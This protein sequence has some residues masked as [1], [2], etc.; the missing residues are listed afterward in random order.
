[1]YWIYDIPNWLLGLMTIAAF[2]AI[3][4]GG[5]MACRPMMGRFLGASGQYND[6]VSYLFA[7]VGVLYGLALGL[8]AVA[9]WA[10]FTDVDGK[11]SKEAA[12]LAALYRDLD[13]YPAPLR[14]SLEKRLRDYTNFVIQKD[15]PAHRQGLILD[16]G[17][18]I[19]EDIENELIGFEPV[20]EREKIAHAEVLDSLDAALESR[21]FRIQSVNSGLPP[22]L[23]AVVLFGA[24]L[25]IAMT[26]LF[27]VENF[28]LH[29]LLVAAFSASIGLLVFLTAAMDNPFRGEFS[30]SSDAYASVLE[31]A[32][33]PSPGR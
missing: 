22:V 11:A 30:V 31:K 29:A 7:A 15:W 26:Y 8:I 3:S 32:M 9:T 27:W 25:N 2:V 20:K 6:V 21:D 1:M 23:W 4:V 33:K 19:L 10:N 12:S 28:R 13:G 14:E 17:A 24:A 5:L 18:Q 16:G